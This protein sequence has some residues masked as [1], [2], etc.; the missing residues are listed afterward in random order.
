MSLEDYQESRVIQAMDASFA[1]IIMAAARKADSE[2]YHRLKFCWPEI[3]SE[4]KE[5]YNKPGGIIR[6]GLTM[7]YSRVEDNDDLNARS[8]LLGL[9]AAVRMFIEKGKTVKPVITLFK[10]CVAIETIRMTRRENDTDT[11]MIIIKNCL[12]AGAC[13]QKLDAD[14]VGIV[15][16]VQG[17]RVPIEKFKEAVEGHTDPLAGADIANVDTIAIYLVEVPS[18]ETYIGLVL[19]TPGNVV[20]MVTP[21]AVVFP[22]KVGDAVVDGYLAAEKGALK[23]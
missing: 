2:N 9:G 18:G 20:G 4:L 23:C 14:M 16:P 13:A 19:Y 1:A 3:I 12:A 22:I 10:N 17:W 7:G 21:D 5:R 11:A 15:I 6:G 8:V